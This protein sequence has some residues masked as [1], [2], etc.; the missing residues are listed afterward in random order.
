MAKRNDKVFTPLYYVRH[1]LTTVGYN[2][3]LILK[4]HVI[5]NSCGD[6]AFLEEIVNQYIDEFVS[7]SLL[8]GNVEYIQSGKYVKQ[9]IKELE[10]YV[11]GIE[12]DKECYDDC[13]KN[14]N[15]VVER[16]FGYGVKCNFDIVLADALTCDKF[17]GKMDFVIGN[18]PYINC[19]NF[20]DNR[21][22]IKGYSFCKEGMADIYLAFFEKGF[23]MLNKNGKLC[24]ITPS[25]WTTSLSG[26]EFRKYIV[27][28][29]K[30][31]NENSVYLKSV[32]VYGHRKV[33]KG[34]TNYVMITE[35]VKGISRAYFGDVFVTNHNEKNVKLLNINDLCSNG[36]FYF[37]TSGIGNLREILEY[38]GEEYVQVK[39]GFA[40]LND[41]VFMGEDVKDVDF[42]TIKCYKATTG[43]EYDL[44]YPYDEDG[45]MVDLNE[46]MC[47]S[48]G[49]VDWL[50]KHMGELWKVGKND[51]CWWGFGRTQAINDVFNTR[52]VAVTNLIK[53]VDG[54]RVKELKDG[55]GIFS[56][57]Y[58]LLN[59]DNGP[60]AEWIMEAIKSQ[61][62]V[63]YVKCIGTFKSGGYYTYTSKDLARYLN[64][65]ISKE[66]GNGREIIEGV[67]V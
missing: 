46:L 65:K 41:K 60:S 40:T 66:K 28:S 49:V 61:D 34:C 56:G 27:N 67:P 63:E 43:G 58:V 9:L 33:F 45:K 13:I 25:S 30:E 36:K 5:D 64:Y 26:S 11:H 31:E 51:D 21:S 57:F 42:Y 24:Y 55:E 19:H 52:R 47:S 20:D 32:E 15:R 3:T 6:G 48:T 4:K 12:I 39:N 10:T 23:K 2:G 17:D 50:A 16:R 18:P 29:F 7:D 53:N 37:T 1:M 8:R 38:D 14:L 35:F 44:F 54:I 62:F 22:T 59:K